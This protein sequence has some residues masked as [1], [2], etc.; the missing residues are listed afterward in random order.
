MRSAALLPLL[1]HEL[2][3]ENIVGVLELMIFSLDWS[4]VS[5]LSPKSTF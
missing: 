2:T 1:L 5:I 4:L 3:D